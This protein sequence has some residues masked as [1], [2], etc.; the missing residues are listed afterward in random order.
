M[1][2][3]VQVDELDD[4]ARTVLAFTRWAK[5]SLPV[6]NSIM[7]LDVLLGIYL[8]ERD[9]PQPTTFKELSWDLRHGEQAIRMIVGRLQ[10]LQ[11]IVLEQDSRFG[12]S[13]SRLRVAPDKI[14]AL[15]EGLRLMRA[16]SDRHVSLY[17]RGQPG[18]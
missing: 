3:R 4:A 8:A 9:R 6:S 10:E 18:G 7:A 12:R 5:E 16:L 14:G 11:W 15:R 1:D 17:S 2:T 13:I